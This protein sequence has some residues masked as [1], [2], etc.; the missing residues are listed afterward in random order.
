MFWLLADYAHQS[1][2]GYSIVQQSG[3]EM[4]LARRCYKPKP[5]VNVTVLTDMELE[6]LRMPALFLVGENEKIYSAHKAVQRLNRVAPQ[7]KA[8]LVPGAGHDLTLAQAGLVNQLVLDFL[9]G[10]K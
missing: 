5:P 3:E 1:K 2:F 6:S 7:I 10:D 8:V 9:E 4:L